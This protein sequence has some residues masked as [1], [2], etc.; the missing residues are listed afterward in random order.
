MR[1][2]YNCTR[3]ENVWDRRSSTLDL[4]ILREDP[5]VELY[6]DEQAREILLLEESI[7]IGRCLYRH[8]Q[9][10][11]ED[12]TF[13][14]FKTPEE[15]D[16]LLQWRSIDEGP[17]WTSADRYDYRNKVGRFWYRNLVRQ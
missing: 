5:R 3:W 11:S 6:D 4:L 7:V 10:Q 16:R 1:E 2:P 15:L 17:E 8:N 12:D 14:S 9:A 13:Y